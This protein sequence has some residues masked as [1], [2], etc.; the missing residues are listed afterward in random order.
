MKKQSVFFESIQI[1]LQ[2][3]EGTFPYFEKLPL[4]LEMIDELVERCEE[5]TAEVAK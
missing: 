4:T 5:I 1:D 2:T 3:S